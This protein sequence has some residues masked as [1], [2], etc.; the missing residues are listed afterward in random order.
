MARFSSRWDGAGHGWI[1]ND[2]FQEKLRPRS[3]I[4]F[5]RPFWQRFGTHTIEEIA[6]SERS[7]ND[8]RDS[9]FLSERQNALF[10]FAFHD[11]VVNLDKIK[12]FVAYNFLYLGKRA[13]FVMRDP[14]ITNAALLLPLTQRRGV[15]RD[16]DRLV[17]LH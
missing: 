6:A 11:R 17:H 13:G 4:Q 9:A 8:H 10:R 15:R 14:D 12:L 5:G 1:S 7:I 3:T 16:I 2:P